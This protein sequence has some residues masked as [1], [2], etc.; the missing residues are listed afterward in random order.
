MKFKAI[1]ALYIT[2]LFLLTALGATVNA[3]TSEES[4][5]YMN[6]YGNKSVVISILNAT[7]HVII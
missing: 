5:W 6:I 3:Q 2:A 7:E 4:P 1:L